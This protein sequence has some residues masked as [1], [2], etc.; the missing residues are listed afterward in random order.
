MSKTNEDTKVPRGNYRGKHTANPGY[1]P[2]NHWVS[3]DSCGFDIR[4]SD[5]RET[6]DNRL[7]C[8]ADWEPRHP[9][10]FVRAK[11]DTIAARHPV[12]PE[13][14]PIYIDDGC[15]GT[16]SVA[17]AAIAGDSVSGTGECREVSSIPDG[18]FSTN[19]L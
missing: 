14:A 3:C 10:E 13:P 8:P 16:T 19:P 6:W 7:V 1:R 12:R 17:G 11:K 5:I 2:M 15:D 9:Q 4:A 18:T